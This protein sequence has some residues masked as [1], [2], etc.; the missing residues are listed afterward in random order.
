M[1]SVNKIEMESQGL[2]VF[3]KEKKSLRGLEGRGSRRVSSW[4]PLFYYT[5]GYLKDH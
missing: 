3:Q 5:Y 1:G 4:E 2:Q